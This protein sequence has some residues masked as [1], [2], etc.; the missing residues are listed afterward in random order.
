MSVRDLS[1][2]H[3]T[4]PADDDLSP[5]PALPGDTSA[6]VAIVGAGYTGLWTAYYLAERDP[7][8]RIVVVEAEVAGFGASGR[9]GG[10]CSALLPMTLDT[11]AATHGRDGAARLSAGRH[12]CR[13]PQDTPRWTGERSC[14]PTCA[15]TAPPRP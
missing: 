4:L 6:D 5:R 12:A 14:V 1:L 3:A 7:S 11:M 13:T 8:L 2:W 9:N 15:R 10:W